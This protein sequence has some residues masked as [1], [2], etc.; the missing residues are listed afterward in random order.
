[1]AAPLDL[2]GLAASASSQLHVLWDVIGVPDDERSSFLSQVAADVA[3]TYASRVASQA[4]RRA[5]LEAEI[6]GLRTTI[7]DMQIAMEEAV[8]VVRAGAF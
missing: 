2:T 5:I 8:D 1:M 7:E 6:E 4:D 3:A